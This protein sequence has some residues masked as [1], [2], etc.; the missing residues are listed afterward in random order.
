M[1]DLALGPRSERHWP[2]VRAIYLEGIAT[3][4]ATFETSAPEWRTWDEGHLGCCRLVAI[5]GDDVLGWAALSPVSKRAVY[6]GVTEVSVYVAE[7]ARGRGVGGRLLAALIAESEAAGIW[8]LQAAIFAANRHSIHVHERAGF[9]IVGTR[10]RI[11]CRDGIWHDVVLM[12]RRS[13]TAGL[14]VSASHE[15][16]AARPGG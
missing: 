3:G 13:R 11:G 14:T 7:R 4:L 6:R 2:A 12:E 10:E 1:V 15:S 8:T 5:D 16:E 9:R